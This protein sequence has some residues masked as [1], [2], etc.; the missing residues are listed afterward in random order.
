MDNH[1]GNMHPFTCY[2][3]NKLIE[4]E[5]EYVSNILTSKIIGTNFMHFRGTSLV[6]DP[7]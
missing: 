6:V 7:F 2:F 4:N 5:T 1:Y 3:C